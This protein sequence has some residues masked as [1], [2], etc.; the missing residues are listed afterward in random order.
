[1]TYAAYLFRIPQHTVLHGRSKDGVETEIPHNL[2]A[3]QADDQ[4]P[5]LCSLNVVRPQEVSQEVAILLLADVFE[6]RQR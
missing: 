1:M 4:A 5:C 6:R 2:F 3:F